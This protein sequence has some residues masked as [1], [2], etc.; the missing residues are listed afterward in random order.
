MSVPLDQ[1]QTLAVAV[2][3]LFFGQWLCNRV[4]FLKTFCIPAPVAGGF[5]F[6]ILTTILHVTNLMDI[7]F[8]D[9]LREVAM[10]FFFTSVGFQANLKVRIPL[11]NA[12]KERIENISKFNKFRNLFS[13]LR[14]TV[15]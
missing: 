13:K 15:D 8:D 10:V 2:A 12:S 14:T 11:K 7:D 1:Y 9:S 3:V 4:K 5:V 6:A